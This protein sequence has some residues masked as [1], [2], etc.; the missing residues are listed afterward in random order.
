[1]VDSGKL[2]PDMLRTILFLIALCGAVPSI[3]AQDNIV[4][5]TTSNLPV[6]VIQTHGQDILDDPKIEVD[7]G[8][9]D[10]GVGMQNT[11]TD[12]FN[13]YDG[14]MGIE[15]RG[16][17][18]QMFPKKQYGVEFHDDLG[19]DNETALFG[20]PKEEDWVFFAPYNDKSLM[21]DVLAYK[22]GR[23]QGRYAPRTKYCELVLNGTYMGVYVVIEKIKRDKGRVNINKLD[24]EEISG[25]NLTGGYIIKIDKSTGDGDGGWYSAQKPYPSAW[26]STNFQYEEPAYDDIVPEQK[27]YIQNYIAQFEGAL[28][29]DGFK[30]PVNGYAKYID[31]NSFIDYMLIQEVTKNVDG[32]R[33][34]TFFYKQR[35]S[36][37]GKLSM[38]PIWDFNLGFGNADYCTGGTTDGFVLNFNAVC[39]DDTW[40]IPFWWNR[41]LEDEDFKQKLTARWT[42]LRAGKWQEPVLLAYVDSVANVLNGGAQQRNFEAW[43]VLG[44]KIWPNFF[45]GNTYKQEVDYLKNWISDRLTWLDENLPQWVTDAEQPTLNQ[46][47]VKLY[48]NPFR[49]ALTLEY[50]LQK[51]GQVNLQLYDGLGRAAQSTTLKSEQAGHYQYTWQVDVPGGFYYYRLQQGAS[52][53]GHGK[54]SKQ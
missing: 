4:A 36:D 16:S 28:A 49:S 19:K 47:E 3:I 23:D 41:L 44:K 22:M 12:A 2:S 8:I 10:N 32:Y 39:S 35:D 40:Q 53:L 9:V 7:L 24:P 37:G 13:V 54:L 52:M 43:S 26:Q 20:F 34:S 27:T 1:M 51:P 6:I 17:S 15:I 45:V 42:E 38:G 18:S 30:D 48:P 50:T 31:V 25:D 33:L 46:A 5:F 14:K 11:A 21:R 29:G